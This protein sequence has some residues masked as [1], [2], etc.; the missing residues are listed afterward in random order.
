MAEQEARKGHRS[1]RQFAVALGRAFGG[2]I[3]F[4][5][6]LLMTMEMWELG[7]YMNRGRLA[8]FLAVMVPVLVLLDRYSGFDEPFGWPNSIANA[9]AAY[10]LAFLAAAVVLVLL[11]RITPGMPPEEIVGM[12]SLQAVPGSIGAMLARS[13]FGERNSE[14]ERR[15]DTYGGEL[16]LIMIGALF[17]AFTVAPTE[18]IVL[19]AY[20]MAHGHVIAVIGASLLLMHAFVY[21]LEF[22]GQAHRPEGAPVWS[23]FFRLTMVGYVVSLL[24]SLY[25]L[26]TFGRT[27]GLGVE[28]VV[29]ITVVLAFPSALG[30]A[31]ARLIL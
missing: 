6:P 26:W 31:A 27:D 29:R 18:E 28:A 7:F 23:E 19:I 5:L 8:L 1:N 16:F 24:V 14:D 4:S 30:A 10:A 25:V 12:I 20:T 11:A 9:F 17:L 13:Q 3:V 22:R 21:A 15:R 2:A